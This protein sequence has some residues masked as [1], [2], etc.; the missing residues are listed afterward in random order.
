MRALLGVVVLVAGLCFSLLG[1][2]LYKMEYSTVERKKELTPF[3]TDS[4]DRARE[5]YAK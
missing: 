1:I 3:V 5:H 4:M 2:I